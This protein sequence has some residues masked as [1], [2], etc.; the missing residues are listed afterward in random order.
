MLSDK[1]RKSLELITY[2]GSNISSTENDVNIRIVKAWCAIDMLSII[3]KSSLS[4]KLKLDFIPAAAVS[5]LLY[6]CT[7]NA[8]KR[9]SMG[10]I[11]EFASCF[12]QNLE[13]T[14]HKKGIV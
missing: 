11:Q 9:S 4:D 12:E 6:E 13:V 1:P 5:V 8:W 7:S 2:I 14:P 10:I 3:W